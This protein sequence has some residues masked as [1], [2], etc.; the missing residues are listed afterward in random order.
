MPPNWVD[1]VSGGGILSDIGAGGHWT[2]RKKRTR[3]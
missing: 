2:V 3:V 1:L